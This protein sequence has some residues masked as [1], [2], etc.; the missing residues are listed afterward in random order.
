M[1]SCQGM[2]CGALSFDMTTPQAAQ[3]PSC[4][5]PL[6]Q[7]RRHLVATLREGGARVIQYVR[8]GGCA[9]VRRDLPSLVDDARG[10]T[11]AE[12]L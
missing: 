4:A 1:P 3:P 12:Q 11:Y 6:S 5:S 7:L 9:S 8:T 10:S 2:L